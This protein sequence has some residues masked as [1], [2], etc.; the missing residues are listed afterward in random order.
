VL[1]GLDSIPWSKLKHAYGPADDVPGLLRAL[2]S[3][4]AAERDSAQSDLFGNIWH[5]GTVYEA[6]AYAVPFLVQLALASSVPDRADVLGLLGAIAESNDGPRGAHDEVVR[7]ASGVV[8]LLAD[9]D[10]LVRASAGYVLGALGE[11]AAAIGP[12]LRAAIDREPDRLARAGLLLGLAALRDSSAENITWLEGRFRSRRD[13]QERFATAIALAHA[14][15]ATTPE[16]AILLLAESCTDPG[17]NSSRF[18]GLR[19]DTAGETMPREALVAAGTAAYRALP[20]VL[21]ALVEA[22]DGV[23]ASFLLDDALAIAFG[24]AP[25]KRAP[26]ALAEHQRLVLETA[27]DVPIIWKQP[28]LFSGVLSYYHLPTSREELAALVRRQPK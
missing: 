26:T 23:D 20:I 9:G 6:T 8:G 4:D 10:P 15:R 18:E 3:T 1:E 7:R 11:L 12:Q 25:Q 16:V 13:E 17:A 27:V 24:L 19:W 21:K 5:Q 28:N 14:A 2:T 22:D